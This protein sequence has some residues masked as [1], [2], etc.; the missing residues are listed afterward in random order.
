[1]IDPN[2]IRKNVQRC[3][4]YVGGRCILA[5]AKCVQQDVSRSIVCR[6]FITAVLP[7]DRELYEQ[8][9]KNKR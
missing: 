8:Y 6:Y 2:R 5:D 4:N 9:L 7:N 3:C 1:M